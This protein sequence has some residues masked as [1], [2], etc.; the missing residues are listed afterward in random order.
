MIKAHRH[1]QLYMHDIS[2]IRQSSNQGKKVTGTRLIAL[3]NPICDSIDIDERVAS[4]RHLRGFGPRS[5]GLHK[6]ALIEEHGVLHI[7]EQRSTVKAPHF[8]RSAKVR[9]SDR[10]IAKI[11]ISHDGDYAVAVCMAFDSPERQPERKII[12]DDG[13]GPPKHEPQWGDEGWFDPVDEQMEASEER[14]IEGTELK[15][16][17]EDRNSVYSPEALRD[18]VEK[19]LEGSEEDELRR[20]PPLP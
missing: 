20:L 15:D 1:R 17:I 5:Q 13:T 19:A 4:E 7:H 6:G 16:L 10:Q 14:R 8:R 9:D 12:V 3:I 2:I 18:I 11:N